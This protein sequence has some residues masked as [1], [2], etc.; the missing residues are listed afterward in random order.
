MP[1]LQLLKSGLCIVSVVPSTIFSCSYGALENLVMYRYIEKPMNPKNKSI[2]I[3]FH[4]FFLRALFL[5][6]VAAAAAAAVCCVWFYCM[7][8]KMAKIMSFNQ[9]FVIYMNVGEFYSIKCI[10]WDSEYI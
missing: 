8:I 7:Y 9:R 5:A 3:V 2:N 4:L 1:A 6:A 10:S